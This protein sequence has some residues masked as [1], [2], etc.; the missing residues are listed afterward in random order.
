MALVGEHKGTLDKLDQRA[1]PQTSEHDAGERAVAPRTG[2]LRGLS[3]K[4]LAL[5]ILFVMLG[6]V[7]IFV[8][9][10]A[11]FRIDW[12]QDRLSSAKIAS[13]VLEASPDG[14]V[15]DPLRNQILES[16]GAFAVA[17]KRGEQ[18]SPL[19]QTERSL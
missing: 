3:I 2:Y 5:T 9:S 15:P 14:M 8:P 4:L 6:E 10:I 7:L 11:K 19:T 12:L 1:E 17:V 18:R 13:L 16:A